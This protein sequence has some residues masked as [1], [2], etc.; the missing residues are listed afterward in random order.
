M[1]K[2]MMIP[3]YFNIGT[4]TTDAHRK[5]KTEHRTALVVEETDKPPQRA[6]F[7]Q[8]AD[9]SSKFHALVARLGVAPQSRILIRLPNSLAY[10]IA[11]YGAMKAGMIAVPT[12]TLL[13]AKEILFLAQDSGAEIL[14][15]DRAAW[16]S[17]G[18]EFRGDVKIRFVFLTGFV[19]SSES[20]PEISGMQLF[21]LD[22]ELAKIAEIP[23][24]VKTRANDSAY[25]VYTSG[26]TGYPKGVLHAHRS[27]LG[28]QPAS[29]Y[30]FDF[31]EHD[32]ILHSGK[33]NWTYVLGTGLMDPMYRGHSVVVYEGKND[34]EVWIRLI[35]LYN[36]SIFIGVPTVY[37][38]ILQKTKAHGA[39][40]PSLRYGMCAGEHLSDEVLNGWFRRFGTPIYEG[41]GMSEYS[42]YISQNKYHRVLP[43][44][45]GKIQP[46]RMVRLV[47]ADLN[48]VKIGEEGMLAVDERDPSLF[49]EYWNRPE[50]NAAA[51][52]NGLFLTGDYASVDA[53]GYVRFI[54]RKDEIIK[55]F[56]Y[57]VSPFEI[58]R[59]M[60][61]HPAISECVALGEDIGDSKVLVSLCVLLFPDTQVSESELLEFG[62][63][64]LADY[65]APKRIHFFQ[66]FPRTKNG[67]VLRRD[68]ALKIR[69]AS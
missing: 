64:N 18:N 51:R 2:Q 20:L 29:D 62:K 35:R 10:P 39:D 46:G 40:V 55:S 66:D 23:E 19:D 16:S 33:F 60:K 12:S 67:K 27:L 42:Y 41:L 52:K 14:V 11:F 28:R 7:G 6:T 45:A 48:D 34:P 13:T 53:E 59:V 15:I 22:A 4:A 21:D 56:G 17:I 47:D 24:P 57:R 3:E 44:S 1:E 38:Q 68:L 5:T 25:L 32:Y 65:K 8:L 43:G 61:S 37:R 9:L 31:R 63:A 69:T 26:T 50:E 54:G 58:E 36:C 49:I 30:W